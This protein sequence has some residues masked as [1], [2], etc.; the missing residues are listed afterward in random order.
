[1]DD[2]TAHSELTSTSDE[3]TRDLDRDPERALVPAEGQ[4]DNC[5]CPADRANIDPDYLILTTPHAPPR[6]GPGPGRALLKALIAVATTQYVI[7]TV[8]VGLA[9]IIV[10]NEVGTIVNAKLDPIIAALKRL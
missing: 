1:M 8:L 9:A 5:P 4:C 2:V 3:T 7:V 10:A 6:K